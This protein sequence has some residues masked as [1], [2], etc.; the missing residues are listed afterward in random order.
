MECCMGKLRHEHRPWIRV[1]PEAVSVTEPGPTHQICRDTI[2][3]SGSLTD[4]ESTRV[5]LRLTGSPLCR[6]ARTES[7]PWAWLVPIKSHHKGC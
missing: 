2:F 1:S 4:P 5:P 7:G 6:A 3:D